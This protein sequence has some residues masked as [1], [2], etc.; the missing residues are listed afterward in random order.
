QRGRGRRRH[1]AG[2]RPEL[3]R[4]GEPLLHHAELCHHG[5]VLLLAPGA[6]DIFG[7]VAEEGGVHVDAPKGLSCAHTETARAGIIP[8]MIAKLW[9]ASP[10]EP[11]GPASYQRHR[12]VDEGADIDFRLDGPAGETR[13]VT[14]PGR[15]KCIEDEA[16][17]AAGERRAL[18]GER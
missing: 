9:E 4:L 11:A 16:R 14:E 6:D 1:Q 8:K 7:M 5:G 17:R 2:D 12:P 3:A 13:T 18:Q 10:P 15:A